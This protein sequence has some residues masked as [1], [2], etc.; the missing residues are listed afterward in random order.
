MK[1]Y[2]FEWESPTICVECRMRWCVIIK[3]IEFL[4]HRH[5]NISFHLLSIRMSRDEFNLKPLELIESKRKS[6]AYYQ[7]DEG[8]EVAQ[9]LN[10]LFNLVN[11]F[12]LRFFFFDFVYSLFSCF[13]FLLLFLV[14][15]NWLHCDADFGLL[16]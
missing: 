7:I 12:L 8:G 16:S 14:T 15:V 13:V 11:E 1:W 10:A 9:T 5:T 3:A 2:A 4:S 6:N